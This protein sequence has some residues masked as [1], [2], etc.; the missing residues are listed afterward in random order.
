MPM[1]DEMTTNES[2]EVMPLEKILAELNQP[3]GGKLPKEALRAAQARR[4]EMVPQLIGILEDAVRAAKAGGETCAES[5][6]PF[7]AL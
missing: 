7:L 3:Y 1:S 5:Q 6:G 2:P 4:D